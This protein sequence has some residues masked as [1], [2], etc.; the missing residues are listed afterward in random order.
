MSITHSGESED[1]DD[2]YL[3]STC[4]H[5]YLFGYELP[6]T[7]FILTESGHAFVLATKKKCDFLSKAVGK[8][9]SGSK[10]VSL[11]CLVKG[12]EDGPSAMTEIFKKLLKEITDKSSNINGKEFI[13]MGILEKE[14]DVENT[15]TT[16]VV[17][18]WQTFLNSSTTLQIKKIN[19]VDISVGLS[20]V[21]STKDTHEIE[22]LRK[23]S[24]LTN[25]LL[26]HG[27]ISRLEEIIENEV[28][29]THDTL[30]SELESMIEDPSKIKLNIP[31]DQVQSCYNPIIQSGGEYDLRVS[32]QSNTLTLKYDV[33]TV[34]FGSRYQFYCSNIGRTFLVDPPKAVK[35]TYE[36]L[37]AVQEVCI[38]AMTP[39]TPLKAVYAAAV[40]KLEDEKRSDLIEKLPKSLGFSIGLEFRDATLLLTA[41]N[42]AIFRSGMIF[43][44]SVGFSDL[45]LNKTDVESTHDKSAVSL[46]SSTCMNEDKKVVCFIL[47]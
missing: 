16:S 25:K 21:M 38:A 19:K 13:N 10:I 6:D 33:I 23:S 45:V 14:W 39:G 8:A 20:I 35:E 12:K 44:L 5:Q 2:P 9:P 29:V 32:A 15:S 43:N 22:L 40:K 7:L 18:G 4:A 34:S 3:K 36:I 26:K 30:S 31:Q 37:V 46:S 41:K 28:Q 47:L 27:F 11:T 1:D 24:V 17:G 42:N